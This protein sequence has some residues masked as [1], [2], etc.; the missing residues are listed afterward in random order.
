[1][2]QQ[3]GGIIFAN[4][5]IEAEEGPWVCWLYEWQD[6]WCWGKC[7]GKDVP[8]IPD[9]YWHGEMTIN[10]RNFNGVIDKYKN[11]TKEPFR[12]IKCNNIL[13]VLKI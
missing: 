10:Y 2:D 13:L 8:R 9:E 11:I 6:K 1:M 12:Y 3:D 7:R 5:Y 4:G